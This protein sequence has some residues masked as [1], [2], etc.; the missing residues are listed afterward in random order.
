MERKKDDN[1]IVRNMLLDSLIVRLA[2]NGKNLP[3]PVVADIERLIKNLR[4]TDVES[5]IP[6]TP[7]RDENRSFLLYY[8]PAIIANFNLVKLS[9]EL[10][11]E[12]V[13]SETKT[14]QH[15]IGVLSKNKELADEM[16]FMLRSILLSM[17]QTVSS[18]LWSDMLNLLLDGVKANT[19]IACDTIYFVLYLLARETDG[20]RQMELLRGL[21]S[22]A[23]SKENIPL[24]L[25]TYRSLSSSSSAVLRILSV[26]LHTKLWMAEN[27][28]Y[29]FLHKVL[30]SDD[31]KLSAADKWEMNVVKA[32]AIKEICS[33]K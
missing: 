28:T 3:I 25:N 23:A 7:T 31:E 29:Q 18:E 24:V 14:L 19:N 1:V 32:N 13:N 9:T 21:T 22:F 6:S 8:H 17:E 15:L 33:Q 30:I 20:R 26:D 11:I 10:C 12:L 5:K 2:I 16:H 4:K 27:R